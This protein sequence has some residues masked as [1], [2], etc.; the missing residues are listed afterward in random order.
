MN[1]KD[2]IIILKEAPFGYKQFTRR[3]NKL[4]PEERDCFAEIAVQEDG[5][6]WE[7]YSEDDP[8]DCA[9]CNIYS[10]NIHS[11][12]K[13][14]YEITDSLNLDDIS[15]IKVKRLDKKEKPD[16]QENSG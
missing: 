7:G 13:P 5:T 10:P 11:S 3:C 14:E 6:L 4:K 16:A 15:I 8:L 9:L 12:N 2:Q 1:S